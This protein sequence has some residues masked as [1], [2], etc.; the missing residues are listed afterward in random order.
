MNLEEL[1]KEALK[2]GYRLR[3]STTPEYD[4]SINIR[5]KSKQKKDLMKLAKEEKVS[6]GE[7]IRRAIDSYLENW[8]VHHARKWFISNRKI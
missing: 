6:M 1:R 4:K 8:K 2:K 7:I 3:Q 5:L